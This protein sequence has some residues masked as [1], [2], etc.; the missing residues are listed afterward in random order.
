MTSEEIRT[1]YLNF[2]KERG[3]VVISSASLVPENDPTTLFTG[4]GMQPLVPYLLG[5]P[6]PKGKRLVNSQKSFRAED[7]EEIGDNRHT[8]FFEMLGNW[9]LGDYFKAEQISWFFEF[10]TEIANLDPNRLYVS[11]FAG[12]KEN[13]L[14]R[15]DESAEIWK[16]EFAKKGIEARD[17]EI[18][19]LEQGGEVGMQGGR[20]FYYG[21]SKNWWSRAGKPSQMPAG[22]PGGP[23]TEVFFDFGLPHDP[24]YGKECHPNCDCGRFMEIGNSVFM[25]YVKAPD[26]TFGELPKRNVDFGG[27]LERITA[28]ANDDADVFKLASLYKTITALQNKSGKEYTN[29]AYQKSFRIIADHMRGA[30]FMIS[31][32]VLPS[33]TERGYI[34]R[35]LIRRAVRHAHTL[36]L[37]KDTL[38][39]LVSDIIMIYHNFYLYLPEQKKHIEEVIA[40]E[41]KKFGETLERGLR[42]FEKHIGNA[43][44]GHD[45]FIL[46]TTYGFPIE[47]TE[48]LAAERGIT[49]DLTEFE[50]EMEKHRATSRAGAEQKF[51]G[52]LA[53]HSE[54]SVKYHTATHLLHQA[55][56][57]VLGSEVFQKGSNITPER[58]R[59]DFSFGRKMTEEEKKKV[60]DSVNAEIAKSHPVTYEDIPIEE[61]EKRGAIGLF[62]EKYGDK[63][64]VYK[65]G[66]Y[67]LEFCGGPHVENTSQLADVRDPDGS[68]RKGRFKIQKEEAVAQGIRR[69]KAVLE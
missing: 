62:E 20:I 32:G 19:T 29:P 7:I 12:D 50:Q 9:S 46:F 60:E 42:E 30:V 37:E 25:Q 34:L 57:N 61:A 48:E 11:V 18:I 28:A 45:A 35:R 39:P 2:F 3:H 36:G 55:L 68:I 64:R 6:H 54:M 53:D 43:V 52:G 10:L 21:A 38:T 65:I 27:G 5:A 49:V 69:I 24:T 23:D 4:S 14:P 44:S 59:F 47:M 15:D 63:V 40:T 1:A 16:K 56:R 22:E 13:R 26:G 51:K 41:E 8:T 66:D 58:L 67:S 33:N 17:I 31:D